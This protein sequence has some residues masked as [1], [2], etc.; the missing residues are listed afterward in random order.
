MWDDGLCV[1]TTPLRTSVGPGTPGAVS[2]LVFLWTWRL[3]TPGR[4]GRGPVVTATAS[5]VLRIDEILWDKRQRMV[6][7]N[8]TKN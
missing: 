8:V 4:N 1:R 5:P 2:S 7:V 6:Y 3:L